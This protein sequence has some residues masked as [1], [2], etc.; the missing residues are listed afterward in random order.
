M[1]ALLINVM[2]GIDTTS[3]ISCQ[4]S[5]V[6]YV[7]PV[8]LSDQLCS[9]GL[10]H[11]WSRERLGWCAEVATLN[12]PISFIQAFGYMAYFMSSLLIVLRVYVSHALQSPPRS[13]MLKEARQNRHLE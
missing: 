10:D 5:P 9:Q 6:S 4:V 7:W 1:L 12:T 3:P 13:K 8:I 2:V 11:L